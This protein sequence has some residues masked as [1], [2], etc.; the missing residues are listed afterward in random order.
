MIDPTSHPLE[1]VDRAT[2]YLAREIPARS[3]PMIRLLIGLGI[4]IAA[5]ALIRALRP[6][7]RGRQRLVSLFQ[8]LEDGIERVTAPV[9]RKASTFAAENVH[10][11]ADGAEKGGALFGKSLQ[12]VSRRWHQFLS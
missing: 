2:E 9:L 11:L 3:Q 7:P 12:G 4:G 8:D 10:S 5:G 6:A 1:P